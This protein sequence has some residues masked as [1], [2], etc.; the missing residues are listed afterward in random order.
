[1]VYDVSKRESFESV[2]DVWLQEV[3]IRFDAALLKYLTN[4]PNQVSMYC[5]RKSAVKV[6]VGNKVDVEDRLV[7][8]EEGEELAREGGAIFVEL[9]AK[10]ASGVHETFQKLV[11]KILDTPDLL[12][13]ADQLNGSIRPGEASSSYSDYCA[14]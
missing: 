10:T 12:A 14:C 9:S 1:M 6:L 11:T 3:R 7:T 5:T 4:I 2:R 8:T 13:S